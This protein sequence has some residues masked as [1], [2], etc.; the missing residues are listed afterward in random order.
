MRRFIFR[1]QQWRFLGGIT[2]HYCQPVGG[3]R[4]RVQIE[5]RYGVK[6][7]QMATGRPSKTPDDDLYK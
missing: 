6:L 4:F 3:D 5:V 7:G 2:A 1:L